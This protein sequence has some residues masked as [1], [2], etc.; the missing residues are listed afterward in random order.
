MKR[1]HEAE[2]RAKAEA[3]ARAK[4]EVEAEEA[5]AR[6]D[7]I[8]EGKAKKAK[9]KAEAEAVLAEARAKAEA[10][11]RAKAE[12]EARAKAEAEARAKAKAEAILAE[13]RAKAIADAKAKAEA[14][15][16]VNQSILPEDC[17]AFA[18]WR[19][20]T[21]LDYIQ[22][23]S[24]YDRKAM[25][26]AFRRA[27][28][29]LMYSKNIESLRQLIKSVPSQNASKMLAMSVCYAGGIKLRVSNTGAKF[30]ACPS[31][32]VLEKQKKTLAV[33][34]LPRSDWQEAVARY[35][36]IQAI[37][38]DSLKVSAEEKAIVTYDYGKKLADNIEAKILSGQFTNNMLARKIMEAIRNTIN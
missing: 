3:E 4:A 37:D 7:A 26:I 28:N 6:A 31:A 32:S 16:I 27:L 21:L 10:E 19:W 35:R 18:S 2:A 36:A 24:R 23:G 11:A 14:E 9:A 22:K 30:I 1:I 33:K 38:Y 20:Q 25:V 15:D 12:A 34:T 17:P 8:A 13:A 29:D 5:E